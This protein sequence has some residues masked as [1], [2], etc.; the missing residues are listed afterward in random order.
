V[1]LGWDSGWNQL[2]PRDRAG[3]MTF[4][5]CDSSASVWTDSPGTRENWPINCVTWHLAY[6][7]CAWDGGWLPSEL[8]WEYAAAGGSENRL[9]PWGSELPASN[10]AAY[11][12]NPCS[13]GNIL[14][15]GSKSAGMGRYGHQ[16]LDGSMWE[17]VLDIYAEPHPPACIDC[18]NLDDV[19][20][21]GIRVR[22]GGG[23]DF[24]KALRSASRDRQGGTVPSRSS[25]F[26][27][28]RAT[29]R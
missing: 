17:W 29:A 28:A 25:G 7:F 14:P 21:A 10:K 13:I 22:R 24:D 3:L 12:C 9:Y 20:L 4:L 26:R 1:D 16:D 27:C 18:A 2:V 6:A 11:G 8:E 5:K 15:V 19:N 23:W